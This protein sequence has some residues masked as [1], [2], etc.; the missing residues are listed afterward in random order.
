MQTPRLRLAS[1][2]STAAYPSQ[3]YRERLTLSQLNGVHP[4]LSNHGPDIQLMVEHVD[5]HK[6]EAPICLTCTTHRCYDCLGRAHIGESI[7]K[8][9]TAW[10][11]WGASPSYCEATGLNISPPYQTEIRSSSAKIERQART[12][13]HRLE[14]LANLLM[15]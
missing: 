6:L 11:S 10:N 13:M 12:D 4:G 1:P 5:L 14:P 7:R 2:L 15:E 8:Q 3:G 9:R